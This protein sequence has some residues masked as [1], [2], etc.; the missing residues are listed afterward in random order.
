MCNHCKQPAA[1]VVSYGL[2]WN[3]YR[4]HVECHNQAVS[5][6]IRADKL[7]GC[8]RDNPHVETVFAE[9]DKTPIQSDAPNVRFYCAKCDAVS[10]VFSHQREANEKEHVFQVTCTGRIC[11]GERQIVRCDDTVFQTL[12]NVR[13]DGPPQLVMMEP[14]IHLGPVHTTVPANTNRKPAKP[15]VVKVLV[16][17]RRKIRFDE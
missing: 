9:L 5:V 6:A 7:E 13:H 8:H 17:P 16:R 1:R 10:N 11:N 15:E 2:M 3:E 12:K 14:W 4:F